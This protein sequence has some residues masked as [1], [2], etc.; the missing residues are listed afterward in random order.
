MQIPVLQGVFSDGA[1]DFRTSY[2]VNLVPVPKDN[3]ISKGYLRPA[4]GLVSNGA[5]P[6]L[7]RGGINWNGVCYRVMGASLVSVSST[8]AVSVLGDVGGTG[9]VVFDYSFDRLAINSGG[10][11]FYWNGTTLTQVID[12]DLGT[13]IDLCWVDGYFL[14]TDGE[15]LAVTELTDPTQVNPLKYGS[16]EAD[17]DPINALLKL[18]NE[19]YVLNR[20]TIEVFDNVGGEGFPFQRIEGAQIQ[21]GALGTFCSCVFADTIAF[22]G[23]GRNESPAIYV[24][25]NANAIKISTRE[26][27]TLLSAYTESELATS[28]FESKTDKSHVHLWV[29]LPDR[30]LVYDASASQELGQPVW[31]QLTS[32]LTGFSEYR[33]KD[34][35]YAYDRWTIG[36]SVNP[37]VGYLTDEV[38]SHYGS[39][40]RWEFGTLIVYN[41][42]RGAILHELEL[43]CLTGRTAFGLDPVIRTSYSLDGVTWSQDKYVKV[44]KLGDRAKR[45]VWLGQGAMRNWRIQRFNGDS[46]AF[47]SIARLEAR[48]EP[49][50]V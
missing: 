26:I 27:D 1:A 19:I 12:P 21:K 33:A 41:E 32:A 31:F 24:A 4:E 35:V 29:R 40:V 39:I 5:G 37:N 16:S 34:L 7:S 13:V 46:Q 22:M 50:A 45:I 14:T 44:G 48:V 47:I 17:P 20:N 25:A 42:G 3:G 23:G 15:F 49:L 38:S 30:T 8:G 10:K 11:L 2:P 28:V 6:G 9:Q 36:D 18:R 43:V